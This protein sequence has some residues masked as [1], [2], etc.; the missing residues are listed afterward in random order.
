M[1]SFALLCFLLVFIGLG[2]RRPFLWTLAYLYVDIV[3]PQNVAW[4]VLEFV[5]NLCAFCSD[6]YR[7]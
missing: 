1:L 4:G 2:L 7:S 3:S 6:F 5:P